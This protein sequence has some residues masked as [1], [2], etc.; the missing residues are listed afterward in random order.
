MPCHAAPPHDQHKL[1]C[2]ATRSPAIERRLVI[3][4]PS[5]DH[6]LAAAAG[7]APSPVQQHVEDDHE[8]EPEQSDECNSPQ[9]VGPRE[10]ALK[11][12]CDLLVVVLRRRSDD[13]RQ[14]DHDRRE[15]QESRVDRSPVTPS[16]LGRG[17]QGETPGT[18]ARNERL[19]PTQ[20]PHCQGDTGTAERTRSRRRSRQMSHTTALATKQ[21]LTIAPRPQPR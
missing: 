14:P 15:K 4:T 3:Q 17:Q 1:E 8:R 10:N 21:R 2:Y 9:R 6:L 19:V 12:R 13:R 20:A 5:R 11:R 16:R 18:H 7:E